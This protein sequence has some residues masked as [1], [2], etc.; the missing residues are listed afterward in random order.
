LRVLAF[1]T[2]GPALSAAA[3][4]RGRVLAH[5]H[6]SPL[7]RGHAERLLPMLASVMAEAGWRWRDL[8]LVAVTLGPGNFTGL[9]AGIAVAR[10][11]SLALGCPALGLGTLDL[12]AQSAAAGQVPTDPRPILALL[13]ARREEVYAQRFAPDLSPLDAPALLPRSAV[14]GMAASC[15]P[16]VTDADAASGWGD[17]RDLL[18]LAWRRLGEGVAPVAGTALRPLYLRSP[19]A[20]PGAGAS[21]LAAVS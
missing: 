9:R 11:L 3:G 20:R 19:D 2:S 14:A 15:R 7:A 18:R 10:A 4:L 13:D 6:E 16:A 1:D 12:L 8:E 21:L 17:A 5:G